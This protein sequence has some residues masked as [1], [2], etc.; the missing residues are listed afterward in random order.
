MSIFSKSPGN[1]RRLRGNAAFVFPFL[2]TVLPPSTRS[3]AAVEVSFLAQLITR[4]S[5][6]GKGNDFGWNKDFSSGKGLTI[7]ANCAIAIC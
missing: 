5:D 4:S 3:D 6:C 7:A 2:G 1:R